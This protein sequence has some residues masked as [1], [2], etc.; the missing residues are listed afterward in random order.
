MPLPNFWPEGSKIVEKPDQVT[1]L[2]SSEKRAR[3]VARIQ[4][5]LREQGSVLPRD[6]KKTLLADLFRLME[7]DEVARGGAFEVPEDALHTP[8]QKDKGMLHALENKITSATNDSVG[9][10]GSRLVA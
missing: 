9:G 3:E 8:G 4:A 1:E 10:E 2:L 7:E 6:T 5:A